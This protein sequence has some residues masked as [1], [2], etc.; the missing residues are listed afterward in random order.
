[1]N[2]TDAPSYDQLLTGLDLPETVLSSAEGRNYAESEEG[3]LPPLLVPTSPKLKPAA[4]VALPPRTPLTRKRRECIVPDGPGTADVL[5]PPAKRRKPPLSR[6]LVPSLYTAELKKIRNANP[7]LYA[8]LRDAHALCSADGVRYGVVHGLREFAKAHAVVDVIHS[9]IPNI[10]KKDVMEL[11]GSTQRT[12]V[13]SATDAVTGEVIGGLLYRPGA[14]TVGRCPLCDTVQ[15]PFPQSR[16]CPSCEKKLREICTVDLPFV[17]LLLLAVKATHQRVRGIGS[18]LVDLLKELTPSDIP[19][20]FV[21]S[22]Y[23][24]IAFYEKNGFTTN[25]TL[26][27]RFT[28][29]DE[30]SIWDTTYSLRMECTRAAG[31]FPTREDVRENRQQGAAMMASAAGVVMRRRRIVR[32]RQ[33]PDSAGKQ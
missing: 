20:V 12:V 27:W 26:P 13:L 14:W 23:R 15:H 29:G 1:M 21:D 31:R 22:D 25:M 17:E 6:T 16:K 3:S 5:P 19:A 11:L 2:R 18:R 9:Q 32:A 8:G 24:A 30:K 33:S 4:V 7:D 10:P 28:D